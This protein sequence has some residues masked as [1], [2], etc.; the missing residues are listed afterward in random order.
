MKNFVITIL[1]D[2]KSVELAHRC[3]DSGKKFGIDIEIFN[4]VTPKDDIYGILE[5]SGIYHGDFVDTYAYKD[6]MISCFL[7]HH[8]LWW[9]CLVWNEEV[10]IFEHDAVIN[11]PIPK[12]NYK[13]CVNLGKPSYGEYNIPSEGVS[14]LTCM[15]HFP[16]TH[17]YRVNPYGANEFINGS[18]IKSNT[19]D[20]FL[21]KNMF[22]FLEEYYPWPVTAE[23]NYT[24]V[25]KLRG[26]MEKHN[27][28][29]ENLF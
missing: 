19:P 15:N 20:I 9:Q 28:K 26:Q 1:D 11:S 18:K 29:K 10:T 13:G 27:F 12:L 24:T 23:G 21:H 2:P 25:Q 8:F 17:A 4:A 7:S 6:R 3:I 5:E 16:G 22:K 14:E